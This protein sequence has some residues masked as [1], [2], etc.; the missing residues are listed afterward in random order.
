MDKM[1]DLLDLL[2]HEVQDLYSVEEQIIAAMP[3]MIEKANNRELKKA[4]QTHLKVTQK[5]LSRLEQVQNMMGIE[6]DNDEKKGLFSRLFKTKQVCKGM[7]GIIEE[8]N[9]VMKEDMNA[10]VLDAA[11]IASA[12]KIEHYEICGYGTARTYARELGLNEVCQLLEATLN[13]E[14]EADDLLTKL[15]VTRINKE[16]EGKSRPQRTREV[17]GAQKQVTPQRTKKPEA[18]MEMVSNQRSGTGSNTRKRT[19]E[20]EAP[21]KKDSTRST[22]SQE[23]TTGT[24][25]TAT[26]S[27]QVNRREGSTGRGRRSSE[28]D[29]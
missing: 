1:K 10:D 23:R 16:A 21:Q 6:Q 8:G 26:R 9:K 3:L 7:Q 12:Q 20:A 14:Y 28:G 24:K 22:S 13:E 18:E 19:G 29:S 11:I 4:L 2:K 5:Q 27:T 15:A 17:A 25:R